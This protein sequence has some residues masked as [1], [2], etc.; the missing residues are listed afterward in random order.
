MDDEILRA[1]AIAR[2]NEAQIDKTKLINARLASLHTSE[3]QSGSSVFQS[4]NP[5]S[6]ESAREAAAD[7]VM[8]E[9]SENMGQITGCKA[10]A[11]K[12]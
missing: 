1:A 10:G 12:K 5:G 3:R 7:T 11:S 6:D 4:V 8:G 9:E 2:E